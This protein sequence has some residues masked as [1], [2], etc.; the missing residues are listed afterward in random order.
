MYTCSK[1]KW[2]FL[3]NKKTNFKII[4]LG[5]IQ[6]WYGFLNNVPVYA[7]VVQG[8]Y[9]YVSTVILLLAPTK[10]HNNLCAY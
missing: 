5:I 6:Q 7:V 2:V 8:H 4:L 9:N 3:N 1:I 10:V